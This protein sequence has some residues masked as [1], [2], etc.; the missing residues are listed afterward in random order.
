MHAIAFHLGS[1]PIYWYGICVALGFLAATGYWT[2]RTRRDGLGPDFAGDMAFWLML[3]GV[4]GARLFYVL[5]EWP[6]FRAHPEAIVRIDQGGLVFYGGFLGAAVAAW[7]VARQ[8]Q[9]A[10]LDLGDLILS[11]LPLGHAFGRIGCFLNGCCY[12]GPTHTCIGVHYPTQSPPWLDYGTQGLWPTQ[13]I[14]AGWNLAL[15]IGLALWYPRRR[16]RGV[17]S[18][19]Y[20]ALYGL[21]RFGNEFLRGDERPDWH[22]LSQAQWLSLALILAGLALIVARR[23]HG[24]PAHTS[25]AEGNNR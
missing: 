13:L 25:R 3:A 14:E 5:A 11:G 18:G 2:W 20:L 22:G 7:V 15:F 16:Y 1:R 23:W 10:L 6:Y 4:L 17:L 21:Q 9:V 8:R 19:A 24:L 12:G